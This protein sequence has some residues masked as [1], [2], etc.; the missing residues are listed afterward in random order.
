MNPTHIGVGIAI[1]IPMLALAPEFAV[2]AAIGGMAGGI[3]PDIDL[4]VGYHRKTLHYP[5]Y[6]WVPAIGTS[7]VAVLV[8]TSVAVFG[9]F[10]FISAAIHSGMDWFGAGHEP[11]P[12]R[13]TSDEAVYLHPRRKWLRPKYV[14][15][16]DGAPE[17]VA[18]AVGFLTPGALLFES[19]IR[20]LAVFAATIAVLYGLFRKRLPDTVGEWV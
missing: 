3:F 9:A 4:F 18:I 11:R 5:V 6:Y 12:W 17:D 15:R 7:I 1:A 16:Y 2:V 20:E 8:P 19:P 10:F 13:R 14:V